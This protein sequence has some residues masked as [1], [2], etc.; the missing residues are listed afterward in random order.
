MAGGAGADAL[1]GGAGI[2]TADYSGSAVGVSV[3]LASGTGSGGDA[4]GDTL[5]LIEAVTG[6][7]FAD[8]LTGDAGANAL[9]GGAGNDTLAGGAGADALYGG[10][11][12]DSLT[13]GDGNDLLSGGDGNDTLFGGT[14]DTIDG[15]EG[16]IDNDLL[17]LSAWGW[18]G[19]N[20]IYDPL[21]HENGTVQFLD[22]DGNIVGTMAF[23]NVEKVMPCFTPGTM[24]MTD[25]GAIAVE[26]L[27]PG[28]LVETLDHGLRP[29][30]WI[31]KRDLSI[32]DLIVQPRL[33]PIRISAGSL[34]LGLPE[35]D[36]MVSPQHRVLI[37]G[38]RVEMLVGEP[39]V[40]VAAT[41]LTAMPGIEQVQTN[42]VTYIH[43]L[44]DSH[45]I[46]RADG[47]WTESFQPA[48]R[49]MSDMAVEQRAEI[50]TLFPELTKGARGFKAARLSLKAY[51][52]KVVLAA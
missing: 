15:G 38:A 34:D 35:R 27:R 3:N 39:E 40:L 11:G 30:Q 48:D 22:A 28:D 23:T 8:V 6:S 24:I 17:D 26:D 32:A 43:L 19:T 5:S 44:F 4:A 20:I 7:G 10:T 14:Y 29:L 42:G 16:S 2:D 45:E 25:R 41:Y 50:E 36:M 18:S 21:N 31:G 33:Q 1:D 12:D 51:E 49:T 46:I 52:A 47:V 37:D 13:G 9:Y